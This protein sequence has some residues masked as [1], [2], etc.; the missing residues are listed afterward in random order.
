MSAFKFSCFCRF[1][2]NWPLATGSIGLHAVGAAKPAC[3]IQHSSIT[4]PKGKDCMES[5][6]IN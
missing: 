1:W 4:L 3:I 2:Q 5:A 6:K